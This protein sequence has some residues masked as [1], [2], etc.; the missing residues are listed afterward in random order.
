M[1]RTQAVSVMLG[2]GWMLG[3]WILP[4]S[5]AP[6][7]NLA[8]QNAVVQAGQSVSLDVR[9][10]GVTDLYAWQFDLGFDPTVLAAVSIVEGP[11]LTSGGFTT[12]FVPGTPDNTAG[13]LTA[14]AA[15]LIGTVSGVNGDDTI[16]RVTFQAL[17]SGTSA[18]TL[19]NV[20]LLDSGSADITATSLDGTVT[21]TATVPEPSLWLLLATG[22]VGLLG[23]GRWSKPQA[24][25]A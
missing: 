2:L 15:S 24:V 23:F 7:L 4:A 1:S 22:G 6:L 16:A 19:A 3:V 11:F 14:T 13:T 5:A 9:L 25:P 18:L 8:P 12:S 10:A 17:K 20:I 21:V